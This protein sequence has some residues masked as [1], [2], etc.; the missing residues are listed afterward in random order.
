MNG[1][2]RFACVLGLT[3]ALVANG[4]KVSALE[5]TGRMAAINMSPTSMNMSESANHISDVFFGSSS[6]GPYTLSWK[7]IYKFS[8]RVMIDGRDLQRGIDYELDFAS[9]TIT[10]S[11]SA[12]TTNVLRVE[13]GC[14]FTQA[15]R[16]KN[17]VHMP[18]QLDLLANGSSSLQFT[19]S[20]GQGAS[21]TGTAASGFTAYGLSGSAKSSLG[22][23]STMF[24]TSPVSS[25][26]DAANTPSVS[27]RS[28]LK[29]AS[30]TKSG[31]LQLDTSYLHVGRNFDSASD[32]KL[33]QGTD[34]MSLS[35]VLTP[36]KNLSL[37]SS[38]K[39][40]DALSGDN[41]GQVDTTSENKLSYATDSGSKLSLAHIS[42]AKE[43]SGKVDQSTTTDHMQFEQ[44]MS[45][46]LSAMASRDIVNDKD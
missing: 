35:A 25:D 16:N 10:F 31:I 4:L 28:A 6:K 43:N 3:F 24:L 8:D 42:V 18:V 13:Y 1:I 32:Y 46:S 33:T 34:A 12:G 19:A 38:I 5:M 41:Q 29:L 14:D 17:A 2:R 39:R 36:T 15:T 44:K 37:A 11:E 20:Y 9:G 26:S 27:D 40:S 21:A 30:A 22:T 23:I 45:S 7:P